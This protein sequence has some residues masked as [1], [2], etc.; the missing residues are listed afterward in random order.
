MNVTLEVAHAGGAGFATPR[1]KKMRE[2][3]SPP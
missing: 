3:K 2:S 1:R